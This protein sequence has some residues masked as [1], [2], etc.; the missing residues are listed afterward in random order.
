MSNSLIKPVSKFSR[1]VSSIILLWSFGF[2]LYFDDIIFMYNGMEQLSIIVQPA[3]RPP[4]G[5]S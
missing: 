2:L 4:L 5:G 1:V 3:S